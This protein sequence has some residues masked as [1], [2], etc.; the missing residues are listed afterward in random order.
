MNRWVSFRTV[1]SAV[2]MKQVLTRYAVCLKAAGPSVLRGRCPLPMHESE[3]AS[4]FSVDTRRNIW[5]CHSQSCIAARD[6]CI[7]GNVLDF[8]ACMEGRSI[9]EAALLLQYRFVAGT[10][11][12]PPMRASPQARAGCG[13]KPLAFRL[14]NLAAQHPYLVAREVDAVTADLFG[15]G[16]YSGPGILAGRIAIP[17]HNAPGEIVAYAGRAVDAFEPKYRFPPSFRKSEEL[18]NLHRARAIRPP[19]II[20]VEGFF[21]C[22]RVHQAGFPNVAALMGCAI[23]GQQ[24]QLLSATCSTVILLLDGDAAGRNATRIIG[25]KLLSSGLAVV[26]LHLP[27]GQQP[28]NTRIADLRTLIRSRS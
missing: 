4:S 2:T 11:S 25:A 14:S 20:L 7:G 24:Q 3:S 21:D 5:A 12:S 9:R 16:Y 15:I 10:S 6:G 23:S 19:G 28:D 17:I 22:L 18:F 27:E 8:V 26:A 1:K 13:N